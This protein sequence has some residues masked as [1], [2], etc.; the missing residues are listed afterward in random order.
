MQ[1]LRMRDWSC[2]EPACP[3]LVERVEGSMLGLWYQSH[4]VG[5]LLAA[6]GVGR[7]TT[8]TPGLH[9]T[10]I[11][12]RPREG[13]INCNLTISG[14]IS[15][16]C[17]DASNYNDSPMA[18]LGSVRAGIPFL[19]AA[20]AAILITLGLSAPSAGAGQSA[21]IA[22]VAID[23]DPSGN[24][25]RTVGAADPCVSATLGQP[26]V[27]DIVVA[28]PGVPADRGIAAYQFSIFY[29]PAIVWITADQAA[30]MLLGQASRSAV[31]PI[32]DP[33]PDY[34]GIY[35]SWGVDFGPSGIEPAGASETGPGVIARITLLPK[36]NGVSPLTLNNVLIIDAASDRISLD[37]VLSATIK[38]GQPCPEQRQQPTASPTSAPDSNTGTDQ[39]PTPTPAPTPIAN[40]E[41]RQQ[42]TP[43]S[44]LDANTGG[45]QQPDSTTEG[46]TYTP[47]P[48][49]AALAAARSP[50]SPNQ[51][52]TVPAMGGPPPP[53]GGIY[54]LLALSGLVAT[55][56]GA[57]LLVA[58]R[59]AFRADTRRDTSPQQD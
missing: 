20:G 40:S 22:M 33:K 38:V 58:G 12:Y 13:N 51:A 10:A 29:D 48:A 32:A 1:K 28:S 43:A 46:S 37:S 57:G 23:A 11:K 26:V 2:P 52:S 44:A 19:I 5:A 47:G 4:A 59:L 27:I 6:P 30:D 24:G 34:N 50:T 7:L 3:E 8:L 35:D 45:G 15:V 39:Q 54:A 41:P 18:R 53:A 9:A 14:R 25:P 17:A 42:P 21:S 49:A 56:S 16:A 31:I 55:L 36:A